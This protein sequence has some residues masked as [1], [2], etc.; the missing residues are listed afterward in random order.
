MDKKII[1]KAERKKD[2]A[3]FW[4]VSLKRLQIMEWKKI[5]QNIV[6]RNYSEIK[7]MYLNVQTEKTY[8]MPEKMH[9]DPIFK[10]IKLLDLKGKENVGIC[11]KISG[12]RKKHMRKTIR[13]ASNF[14][15]PT[16]HSWSSRAMLIN[17]SRKLSHYQRTS[18]LVNMNIQKVENS[19][20]HEITHRT[21]FPWALFEE[22]G[23]RQT[24][25]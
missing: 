23:G 16:F 24:T 13:L 6:Q 12:Q 5:F 2:A 7:G 9:T 4:L 20:G 19:L 22:T 21:W 10:T 3:D 1:Q 8:S 25:W 17:T 18:Q 14:S 11:I 15:T